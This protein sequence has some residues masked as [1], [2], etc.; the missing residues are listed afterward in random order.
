MALKEIPFEVIFR[1]RCLRLKGARLRMKFHSQSLIEDAV[2]QTEE[3]EAPPHYT[4]QRT[5]PERVR[6]PALGPSEPE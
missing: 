6:S 4:S 5:T 2:G 3:G 1:Q